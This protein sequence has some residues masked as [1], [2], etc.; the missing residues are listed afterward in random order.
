MRQF[1]GSVSLMGRSTH[2]L[3]RFGC[4]GA[5]PERGRTVGTNFGSLQAL[6][7]PVEGDAAEHDRRGGAPVCRMWA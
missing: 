2:Q 6:R 5:D 3:R 1:V 7:A 4:P